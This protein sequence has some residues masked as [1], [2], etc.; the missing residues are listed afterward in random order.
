ML[1]EEVLKLVQIVCKIYTQQLVFEFFN[2]L[3]LEKVRGDVV[4]KK[5]KVAVLGAGFIANIHLESYTRF[6]HDA[7]VVA[8]YGRTREHAMA[9]AQ[10]YAVPNVY[11]DIDRLLDEC[12]ADVVDICVPN[13]L[14]HDACM[15]AAQHNK[16]VI[17]EKPLAMNLQEAD[18]MIEACES[19][20]LMLMYA[21]ELC[22]APKYERVRQ[23]AQQGAFGDVYMLKQGEK[24][25]GPHSKWFYSKETAGG[26]VMMDMGCHALAWFRWMNNNV[27]VKNVYADMKTVFHNK[28]TDCDD[29][30]IAIVEFEN[31][32]TGIAETSW[33]KPGGMDD[34]IEVYGRKGV[35]YADLFRGNSAL[36]YSSDGYEYAAEK[37]GSTKGWTFT[38]FEEAFNQGYPQELEH[39]IRCVRTGETPCV[40]AKDGRAVLEII[41]AA[42]QSAGTGARVTLPE[43]RD[44]KVPYPMALWK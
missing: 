17:C 32:V 14:H 8:I 38:I 30:V 23:L 27:A 2:Y 37:A 22:F 3:I 5:T 33:A 31:G 4:M 40:T 41:Y 18:E 9:L 36:T 11:D 24:H 43:I 25:D 26:G 35:V 34:R 21:E 6:V 13:F 42:Y 19:R 29:N 39:F 12:D 20:G 10:K 7:E 15:K 28:I 44:K 1:H 16:H